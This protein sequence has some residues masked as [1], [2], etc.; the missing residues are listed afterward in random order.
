MEKKG[1]KKVISSR[2]L[3]YIIAFLF[4][5]TLFNFNITSSRYME[6]ISA[7]NNII[8]VPVLTFL[9]NEAT[10]SVDNMLPGASKEITFSVSNTDEGRQN[11]VLLK[12][13]LQIEA[14]TN[15]PLQYKLYEIVDG[16]ETEIALT[17][18]KSPEYEVGYDTQ[19]LRNYKLKILWN[20]T[21]DS[22]EYAGQ[23]IRCKLKLNGEQMV[24]ENE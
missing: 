6:E 10:Y 8:A 15:V 2:K 12:Y 24:G 1:I 7:D 20:E 11:E 22:Y 17:N 9:N 21:D 5:I 23:T 4:V 14:V 19:Y 18:N 3:V 16:V 13:S